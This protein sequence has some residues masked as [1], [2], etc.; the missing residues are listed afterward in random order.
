MTEQEKQTKDREFIMEVI[1]RVVPK[2]EWWGESNHDN[3]SIRNIDI[4]QDILYIVLGRLFKNIDLRGCGNESGRLIL[5]EKK[6]A[7]MGLLD[8][9]FDSDLPQMVGY[10]ILRP[11]DQKED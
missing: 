8:Y 4:Q 6:N 5:R 1:D 10:K 2:S 3:Q 7:L 9:L 11:E